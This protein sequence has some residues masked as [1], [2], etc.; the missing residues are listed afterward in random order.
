MTR[1]ELFACWAPPRSVWS[2][3]A[4]PTLFAEVRLFTD[5]QRALRTP[6]AVRV[7]WLPAAGERAALVLDVPGPTAVGLGLALAAGGY[8][9]VPLFN[10][11]G[12]SLNECVRTQDFRDQLVN[13]ADDLAKLPIRD[14]APPAFLLDSRRLGAGRAPGPGT[15]DNRW[16]VFAQDFPSA[17]LLLHHG[18]RRAVVVMDHAGSPREDLLHVL[19]A[20]A[21]VGLPVFQQELDKEP[22]VPLTVGPVRRWAAWGYRLLALAGL[23]RHNTGGFGAPIPLPEVSSGRSGYR[24][25]G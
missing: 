14:D 4:K 21:A 10:G 6:P 19:R 15:F 22:A 2:A 20:W 3:W 24:G 8:R 12:S 5:Q 16:V 7:D 11:T 13:Y 9:P 18:L 23:H 17:E 1:E 25:F